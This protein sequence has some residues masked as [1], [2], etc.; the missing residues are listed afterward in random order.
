MADHVV[1]FRQVELPNIELG[2]RLNH[3][4]LHELIYRANVNLAI[5]DTLRLDFLVPL[6]EVWDF[7]LFY[8]RDQTGPGAQTWKRAWLELAVPS[9]QT[10]VGLDGVPVVGEFGRVVLSDYE[11][12]RVWQHFD[13]VTPWAWLDAT[14]GRQNY[15]IVKHSDVP[16]AWSRW[17]GRGELYLYMAPATGA[18]GA[19]RTFDLRMTVVRS[20]APSR[21]PREFDPRTIVE[22]LDMMARAPHLE[23]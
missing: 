13:E 3:G 6:G 10:A 23:H 1:D 2:R 7:L 19:L 22:N 15:L 9:K 17:F 8:C 18:G 4:W 12:M 16:L 20:W 11:Y 14:L 5:G 21:W